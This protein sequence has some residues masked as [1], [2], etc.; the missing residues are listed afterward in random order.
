V[1]STGMFTFLS[2]CKALKSIFC[3]SRNGEIFV[4]TVSG[5]KSSVQIVL[6]HFRLLLILARRYGTQERF[7]KFLLRSTVQYLE[8][9]TGHTS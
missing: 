4:K 9:Q 5:N 2:V 3:A 7:Y 6:T 1:N 8:V